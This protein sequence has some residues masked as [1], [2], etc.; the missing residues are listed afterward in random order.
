MPTAGLLPATTG[1]G[2]SWPWG[3]EKRPRMSRRLLNAA[4][5]VALV[6]LAFVAFALPASAEQRTLRVRLA[7]GSVITV[8]VDAPCVPMNQ[9][10]GLPGTP[11]EDLTPSNICPGASAPTPTTPATPPTPQQP[12]QGGNNGG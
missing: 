10:P 8:T 12:Q 2:G 3:G 11:V 1:P 7:T 6:A 5:A 9:I 4:I